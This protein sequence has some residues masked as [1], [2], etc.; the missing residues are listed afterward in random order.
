MKPPDLSL[1]DKLR[2]LY[3]QRCFTWSVMRL[4]RIGRSSND[5]TRAARDEWEKAIKSAEA[6]RLHRA[7]YHIKCAHSITGMSRGSPEREGMSVVDRAIVNGPGYSVPP[8]GD[9]LNEWIAES[10]RSLNDPP[11]RNQ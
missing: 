4:F 2:A 6:N 3:R 10:T 7:M 5:N 8:G 11:L 1:A 9:L